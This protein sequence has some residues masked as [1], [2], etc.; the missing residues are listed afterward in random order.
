MSS[1]I[2]SVTQLNRY[3]SNLLDQDQKLR[4]IMV[5]GEIS[6]FKEYN[7]GHLY[8]SVKDENASVSCVMFRGQA[9]KLNFTPEN[10]M[11][12]I[13]T[14]KASLYDRDGRFQLYVQMMQPEGL[15]NLFLQFEKMKKRLAEEGLFDQKYK[16]PIPLLPGCIGVVTSPS[17]AVIRDIIHVL[18]RRFPGFRL[19]LVPV[20]VQGAQAAAQIAE[21]IELLNARAEADVIIV[22]RG[23]GSMEDLW[24]FNEEKTVRAIFNS[25][26]P[27]VS[28]VG[29]ETDYTIS[30][31]AA[32]LR[33][34]TPSAAAELVVPMKRDIMLSFSVIQGK[35]RSAL[36]VKLEAHKVKYKNLITR[37]VMQNPLE[38]VMRKK[39]TIDWL[40]DRLVQ[41]QKMNNSRLR[42]K[43]ET[44]TAKLDMLSPLKVL[45]RGYAVV[46]DSNRRPLLSSAFVRPL[47]E[48]EVTL[49]DGVL[50]CTVNSIK[51]RRM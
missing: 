12:V 23:G 41:S 37:P 49:Q 30:D 9:V 2:I 51:D 33:A 6:G 18:R 5:R 44:L 46:T 21:A 4:S 39:Q 17:G 16:K 38:T 35:L 15:G 11:S 28:A 50:S 36:L 7:S 42:A 20:A 27:V 10:G 14:A 47:D 45:A 48:V 13:L 31:F 25:K 43:S 34:P 29:H 1:E 26:I 19:Q 3:V 24:A 32:D 40:N 8:F 22:G